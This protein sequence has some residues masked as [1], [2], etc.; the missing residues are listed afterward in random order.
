MT[1]RRIGL[2]DCWGFEEEDFSL[3]AIRLLRMLQDPETVKA[4]LENLK[5]VSDRPSEKEE[6]RIFFEADSDAETMV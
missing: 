1:D 3:K 4:D 5:V 2:E 6:V